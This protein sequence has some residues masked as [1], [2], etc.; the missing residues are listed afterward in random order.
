MRA[1]FDWL[2]RVEE[3]SDQCHQS[4]RDLFASV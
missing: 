2:D 1:K 3:Y 4:A